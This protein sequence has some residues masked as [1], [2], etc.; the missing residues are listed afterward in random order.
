[1]L[2]L[3]TVRMSTPFVA[4]TSQY[5]NGTLPSRYAPTAKSAGVSTYGVIPYA[6]TQPLT[7]F[8]SRFLKKA[9]M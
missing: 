5:P 7:T 9:S 3:P 1:M 4:R 8:Q 2:P 6:P